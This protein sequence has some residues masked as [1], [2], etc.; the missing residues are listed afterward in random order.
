MTGQDPTPRSP[1]L[2]GGRDLPAAI[3]VGLVLAA[4]FL[5]TLFWHPVAFGLV[6]AVLIAIAY[7][8]SD[9]VLRAAGVRLLVPVL[10][11]SSL[12]MLAGAYYAGAAGQAA[13]VAVLL[14]GAMTWLLFDPARRDVVP[15]LGTTMFL[16]VW[17]GFLGSYAVMLAVRPS[18]PVIVLAVIGAAAVTDIGGYAIGV[19]FGRHKVVPSVSPKK[20]WEG[21]AGGLV[22]ATVLAAV[23]LPLIGDTFTPVSAAVLAGTCGVASFLGDVI[24]SMIKRDL[25]VKDLGDFLPGHGGILD[26]VDGIL[27]ALPVGYYA[28]VVFG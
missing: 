28:V 25:D 7:V 12:V 19:P 5:A 22:V 27:L 4:V 1:G 13:G 26:R 20:S 11:A 23:V 16:G 24:Q 10:I 8:E 17:V 2:V 6:V 15:T 14:I 9:R 21:L 3:A 18:G